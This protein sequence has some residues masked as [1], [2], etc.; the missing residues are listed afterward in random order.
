MLRLLPLLIL[1]A[2][3][4]RAGEIEQAFARLYNF[5]F[6][7]AHAV[8]DRYIAANP[9]DP[10]PYAVSAAADL[11][12]ELDRLGIL[13]A[14]F[15][16]DDKRLTEKK[17]LKPDPAVRARFLRSIEEAQSRAQSVL[18]S[19]PDDPNAMYAT[20]LTYGELVD[21]TALV[22][23][24][25]LGSL[26]VAK[27]SNNCAQHLLKVH[28]EV[29]DA[30]VTVGFTEYLVGSLPFFVRWVVRFDNVEGSKERGVEI[31]R[32]VAASNC[33]LAPFGKVLLAL[34]YLREKKP[35]RSA[36]LMAELSR[37]YPENPLF[38]KELAKL[39]ARAPGSATS[40]P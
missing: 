23:K 21:Y 5:D 7:G 31:L 29:L 17:K 6:S 1:L 18:A 20:C 27:K 19:H 37:D 16:V 26:S 30:Y 4:A 35:E 25:H 22:E 28:P 39:S 8:L 36:R 10:L 33:H 14:E 15:L 34:A 11:F 38:R 12:Y 13:E 40:A 9:Q 2:V 24:K 3:P 32:K